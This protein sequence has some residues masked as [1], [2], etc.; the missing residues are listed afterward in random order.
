VAGEFTYL[1]QDQQPFGND[2]H[3]YACHWTGVLKIYPFEPP[4][5]EKDDPGGA[6][7]T[8]GSD[9][10][11][12]LLKL[13][14]KYQA[15]VGKMNTQIANDQSQKVWTKVVGAPTPEETPDA[16]SDP[17]TCSNAQ[18]QEAINNLST[19]TTCMRCH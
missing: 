1:G 17:T 3:C 5:T 4:L 11:D 19:N 9:Y 15:N 18:Q 10:V 2:Q 7:R 16:L 14:T 8:L 6:A 13:N 12:W